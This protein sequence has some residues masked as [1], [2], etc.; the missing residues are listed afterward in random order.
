MGDRAPGA[1]AVG[2]GHGAGMGGALGGEGAFHL[3]EQRQQQEGDAAHALAGSGDG[4]RVGQRAEADAALV[5]VVDE[6]EDLAEVAADPV[7]GVDDDRVAGPGVGQQLL[8]AVPLGGGAGFLVG[9]DALVRDAEVGQGVELAV[10]GLLGGRD[11]GVAEF[12]AAGVAGT[13]CH[14]SSVPEPIAVR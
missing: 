8:E 13:G 11:P 7:E 4:Q 5:Q 9:V 12:K 10:E 3:G 6:V 14:V 2:L 1:A